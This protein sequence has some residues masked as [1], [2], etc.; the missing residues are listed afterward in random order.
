MRFEQA[1]RAV[2]L[3]LLTSFT[4][5]CTTSGVVQRDYIPQEFLQVRAI[6]DADKEEHNF[7]LERAVDGAGYDLEAKPLVLPTLR[8]EAQERAFKKNLSQEEVALGEKVNLEIAKMGCFLI[9]ISSRDEEPA[10]F[11]NFGFAAKTENASTILVPKHP[12]DSPKADSHVGSYSTGGYGYELG[13][14]YYY[15]PST[16]HVYSYNTYSNNAIYCANKPF[17][18]SKGVTL[19][20]RPRFERD[21]PVEDLVWST[22]PDYRENNR[23]IFYSA[24]REMLQAQKNLAAFREI[25]RAHA[26]RAANK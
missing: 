9:A 20:V 12:L 6:S 19:L 13:D 4:V 17:D 15:T 5:A 18:I 8:E 26:L 24:E 10:D 1:T 23:S 22:R 25:E 2:V 7:R 3:L 16:T 14:T 21:L 11:S